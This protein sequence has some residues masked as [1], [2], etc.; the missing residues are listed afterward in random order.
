MYGQRL[1]EARKSKGLTLINVAMI[2]NT[3]HAT[4]SRYENEKLEPSIETL[5]QL[6]KLYRVSSDYII[7]LTNEKNIQKKNEVQ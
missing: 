7:G 6:C 3:T 2:L 5:K 4:I 1:K